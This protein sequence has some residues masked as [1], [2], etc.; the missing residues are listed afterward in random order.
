VGVDFL[1]HYSEPS[2][3]SSAV[4]LAALPDVA[5]F[6]AGAFLAG[7]FFAG[8]V[9]LPDVAGRAAPALLL[10]WARRDRAEAA[11]R[12]LRSGR[13]STITVMWLV[14]LRIR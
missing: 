5:F 4:L 2:F 13:L 9:A 6:A 10:P 12:S 3:V 8:A 1:A 7:A 11:D 14:R